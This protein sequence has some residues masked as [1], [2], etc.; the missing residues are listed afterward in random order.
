MSDNTKPSFFKTITSLNTNFWMASVM[1]LFERWAWYGIYGLMGI[2]LVGSTDTGGLGFDHV[3]KGNIMG[4]IVAILYLLPLFFG[5]I[6]DRIGY[7]ISLII[8]YI[9]LIAGYYL[10]GEVTSYS[11]VYAVF[12]LVAVG[13]AFFILFSNERINLFNTYTL[14]IIAGVVKYIPFASRSSL[15]SMLQISNE[16]EEAAVI[17][18]ASWIKRM[19]KIII[20]IQ[21]S[22]IISGYLLPFMTCLRE[23]SLFTF[24]ANEFDFTIIGSDRYCDSLPLPSSPLTLTVGSYF[25]F[26]YP[27]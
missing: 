9:L 25:L 14:L 20:P 2:Y 10:L 27:P 12:L 4:N 15:N 5:V 7:K 6:A 13:A 24:H 26:V 1:E 23:L 18:N 11:S 22:S 21:K 17:M 16:L 8:S 3:Q 19:T